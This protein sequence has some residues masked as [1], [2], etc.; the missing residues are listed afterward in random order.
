M[1]VEH[2]RSGFFLD[3][4]GVDESN[5]PPQIGD[6]PIEPEFAGSTRTGHILHRLPQPETTSLPRPDFGPD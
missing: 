3:N 6:Q 5:A 2:A 4:V 1:H